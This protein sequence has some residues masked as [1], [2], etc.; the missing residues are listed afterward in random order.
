MEPGLGQPGRKIIASLPGNH[1]LG[2]GTGIQISVRDRFQAFF[3]VGNRVDIVGNHTF[4]SVDTVSLSAM[5]EPDPST[6]SQG[7]GL[8]DGPPSPMEHIWR[9]TKEFL[10]NAQSSKIRAVRNSLSGIVDSEERS[11][12]PHEAYKI[13]DAP[14]M[15]LG[16]TQGEIT[17]FPTIL[18]THVPLYRPP[19]TPCGPLREHWPPSP[20]P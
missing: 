7:L 10:D 13:T 9:P 18:L 6:A 15:K 2:I 12:Y 4:V 17:E 11:K 1:D 3:G 5:G 8:G 14:E 16:M 20:P 19:G